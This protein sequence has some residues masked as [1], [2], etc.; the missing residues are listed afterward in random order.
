MIFNL[1]EHFF[2]SINSGEH[3]VG[4]YFW[5]D[6]FSGSIWIYSQ[7]GAVPS[8]AYPDPHH[9][10]VAKK[11]PRVLGGLI[12]YTFSMTSDLPSQRNSAK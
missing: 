1:G 10:T 2:G 12:R 4:E 8:S 5:V 7:L 9:Q 3:L 11:P 6:F